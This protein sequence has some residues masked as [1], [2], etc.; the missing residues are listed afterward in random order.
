MAAL[1]ELPSH[2]LILNLDPFYFLHLNVVLVLNR[3]YSNFCDEHAIYFIELSQ[4]CI[5]HEW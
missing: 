1:S 3:G 4:K 5:F 2:F